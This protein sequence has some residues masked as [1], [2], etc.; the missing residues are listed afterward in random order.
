[1]TGANRVQWRHHFCYEDVF[2]VEMVTP[3]DLVFVWNI[4]EV[5]SAAVPHLS[6]PEFTSD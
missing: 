3:D 1:M 6:E 5:E 2:V 4:C